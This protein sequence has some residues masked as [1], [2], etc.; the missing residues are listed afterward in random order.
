M[1]KQSTDDQYSDKEAT[2][3]FEAALKGAMNAPHKPLKE[4]PKKRTL[5]NVE[6]KPTKAKKGRP[7]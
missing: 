4:K 7:A 2:A 6:T 5:G 3:R 1:P